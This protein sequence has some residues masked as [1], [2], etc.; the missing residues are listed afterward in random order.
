MVRLLTLIFAFTALMAVNV[1]AGGSAGVDI[2]ET[3]SGGIQQVGFFDLRDR[4]SFLQ[5]TNTDIGAQTV[6]IQIFNVG[7]LCNEK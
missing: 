3:D 2:P 7:N 5:I 6:H 4:E 1:Y